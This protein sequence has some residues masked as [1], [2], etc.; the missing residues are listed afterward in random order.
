MFNNLN[1]KFYRLMILIIYS[2]TVS[3][4]AGT[5]DVWKGPTGIFTDGS[6]WQNGGPSIWTST[7][8][9]DEL[10]LT[11]ED[12]TCTV[13][14]TGSW[15]Y[16]MSVSSGPDGSTLEIVSPANVSIGEVRLGSSGATGVGAT[17]YINQTGGTFSVKDLIMGR[18]GSSATG[19]GYYTISGGTLTYNSGATGKMY[20]GCGVGGAYTE[21]TFTIVGNTPSIQMKA[22]YVGGDGTNS[23]KGTLIYQVG[24]SGVSPFVISDSVSLDLGGTSSTTNLQVTTTAESLPPADIVLVHLTGSSA[25][26]GTFDSLNDGPAA[27]GTQISLAGNIYSLTYLYSIESGTANDI[28]LVFVGS[29]A[30]QPASAP[31]PSAGATVDTNLASLSWTNPNPQVP[32]NPVYCDVYLGTEP[33][34]VNMDKKTLGNNISQ[35]DINI[36]NFPNFGNIQ[37][38]TQYYWAVDVHDGSNIRSGTMWSFTVYHNDAP[39]ANAGP[40]QVVWLG[41]SGTPGQEAIALDGASSDDGSY[42]ILWTHVSNGAPTVTI[43]PNDQDDTI[44]TVTARGTYQFMLAANDGVHQISD[45]VQI[46]VGSTSCD[47]SHMVTGGGYMAMDE[48]Q[49]CVVDLTD[50]AMLIAGQWLECTDQLT[51]CGNQ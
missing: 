34:R 20:V 26:V 10:K 40:D 39:V 41:K 1:R 43:T 21:G 3:L 44:V 17:G 16:R 22:L 36:S 37:N 25:L 2:T 51:N 48:N 7:N 23:G 14:M 42:N 35:V 9:S 4:N 19:K 30:D 11:G 8:S 29:T 6:K 15:V 33:N 49:D 50:F 45:T 28:A 18:A 38:Q 5:L 27:E 13:N 47:A 31:V 32:G 46:I 12:T 24:S